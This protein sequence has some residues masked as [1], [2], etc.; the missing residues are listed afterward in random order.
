MLVILLAQILGGT[1]FFSPNVTGSIVLVDRQVSQSG[2]R[3]LIRYRLDYHGNS[4]LELTAS[5]VA[6]DYDAVVSNSRCK[7]HTTPRRSHAQFACS[8][9]S[10]TRTSVIADSNDRVRCAERVTIA[11]H[12]GSDPPEPNAPDRD[13]LPIRL[14]TGQTLWLS[15][16]L[17]HEHFLYGAYDSLLGVRELQF[18]L[19][20]CLVID[21]ISLDEDQGQV[22]P[23]GKMSVLPRERLD[24]RQYYSAP[25]S[26]YIT[27]LEPGY[28][29]FRFDD[30]PVRYGTEL[31][32]TFWYLIATGT[33]G[34]CYAR[35]TEYQDAPGE[36]YR[37]DGGMDEVLVCEGRWTRFQHTFRT[38]D[39]ATTV[40]ID[41]RIV[42][43]TAGEMWI[44][45]VRFTPLLVESTTE[46]VRDGPLS[47]DFARR[48]G[49]R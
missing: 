10:S 29:Y 6:I 5:D 34:K 47:S 14:E 28:Q 42:D 32:L 33:D 44:D 4:A 20:P 31:T 25:D 46:L 16:I 18:R 30:L 17:E 49:L 7:A 45:D 38:C 36:W 8:E 41:F 39:S 11:I 12:P 3:W 15:L 24:Q 43:A 21:S 23:I 48:S 13:V 27:T 9:G 26:L 40:V 37:L 19:G 2:S 22:S 35:V 1:P